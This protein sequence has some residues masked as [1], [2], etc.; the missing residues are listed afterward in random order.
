[1]KSKAM[2]RKSHQV[3]IWL[4]LF[5]ICSLLYV[6]YVEMIF[7]LFPY[8][9][10]HVLVNCSHSRSDPVPQSEERY[11]NLTFNISLYS[12]LVGPE[13]RS[14]KYFF[15]III[16]IMSILPKG[17]SFTANLGTKAAVLLK[18]RSSTTNSETQ[19]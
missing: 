2:V 9:L 11:T 12:G 18:G 19:V 10:E 3:F 6:P 14:G 4:L 17:R 13:R 8:T 1:M 7:H 5:Y 16:I 15:F